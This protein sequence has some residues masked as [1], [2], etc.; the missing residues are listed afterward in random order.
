[1]K[2]DILHET[3]YRYTQTAHVGLNRLCLRPR[4]IPER[5][6]VESS[7]ISIHPEPKELREHLDYFGNHIHTG[8]FDQ[9]HQSMSIESRSTV[10]VVAGSLPDPASTLPWE[11]VLDHVQKHRDPESLDAYQFAFASPLLQGSPSGLRDF[12]APLFPAGRPILDAAVELTHRIFETFQYEPGTTTISTPLEEILANRRGVCQDFAHLQI[13]MFRALKLPARYV[14]GYV[15]TGNVSGDASRPL[16]GAD[17]SHAWVSVYC[18]PEVGW[19]DLDPTNDLIVGDEHIVLAWARDFS[20]V[21]P[22][23]GLVLG[24]GAHQLEVRVRVTPLPHADG[25]RPS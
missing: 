1:M 3:E 8:E 14:S 13:A 5:Q 22:V 11:G 2:Y 10:E 15:R 12:V 17:A 21:S 24:G 16:V 25:K 7:V 6:T 9:P 23:K 4:D 20:E 18:G 19:V